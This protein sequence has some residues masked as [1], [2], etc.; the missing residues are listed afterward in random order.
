MITQQAIVDEI[1]R[2][3]LQYNITWLD[4]LIDADKAITKINNFIGTKY[5]S[6]SSV[7]DAPTRTYA[8]RS[9]VEEDGPVDTPYFPDE[10]IYGV[11]IP[12]IAMEVL[13]RDEE[14][15][16][17]YNK[18][19]NDLEDGLFQMFQKEF[20]RVPLA[21]RQNPDAGVF[22]A[23]DSALS[24]VARNGEADL[25]VYKFKVHYHI[26]QEDIA[27]GDIRFVED[28]RA[29]LYEDT[30]VV[31]GWNTELIS[32]DGIKV[33]S[34]TGWSRDPNSVA[35]AECAVGTEIT[36]LTDVHY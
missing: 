34:F 2:L 31:K 18:Y 19:A 33:Y 29:Y 35:D 14:F 11:V 21:F 5:P 15:T 16:T 36:L 24:E 10:H 23:A 25:P 17:V 8:F 32:A 7:L 20:N 27:L 6:M 22:F 13:A 30:T 26:N 28:T 12:F 3:T 1:N 4:I 9:G